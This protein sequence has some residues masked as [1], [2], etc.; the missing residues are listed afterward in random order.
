MTRFSQ[1]RYDFRVNEPE[2]QS[3]IPELPGATWSRLSFRRGYSA[4]W[5][6]ARAARVCLNGIADAARER[7]K[8]CIGALRL[9]RSRITSGRQ[10]RPLRRLNEG[11]R[12]SGG[13]RANPRDATADSISA[14][15]AGPS[16]KI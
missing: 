6:S 13:S 15:R 10:V 2:I 7:T 3:R 14:D 16:R 8:R 12:G 9:T 11:R 1:K 5:F 4:R